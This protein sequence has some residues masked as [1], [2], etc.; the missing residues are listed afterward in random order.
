MYDNKLCFPFDVFKHIDLS[1]T[2]KLQTFDMSQTVQKHGGGL[3]YRM[4]Q[5]YGL[6]A[7]EFTWRSATEAA[8]ASIARRK[9][10]E[11]KL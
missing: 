5:E 11:A 2:L 4:A 8:E 1:K 10:V 7:G 6:D 9:A 3:R